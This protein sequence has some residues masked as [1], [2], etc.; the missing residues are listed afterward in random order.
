RRVLR[1]LDLRDARD[2]YRAIRLAQ[3][4]GLGR[5]G[6][7]DVAS[8]PSVS[9]LW[10]M[11]L[12]AA[13]DAVAWEYA[14]DFEAAFGTGLPTLLALRRRRVSVA[15]GI[16][17]T[18][19]TL[20]AERNDT[21]ILRKQGPIAARE[22]SREARRVLAAG[23]VLTSRGRRALRAFDARLRRSR[24]PLNPGA[25]ADLTVASL[26]LWLLCSR[27]RLGRLGTRAGQ[28]PSRQVVRP[29]RSLPRSIRGSGGL[30]RA[31]R[32]RARW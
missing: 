1:D 32:R 8:P 16:A 18:Y 27:P 29:P 2:A 20:L 21:L 25:T 13:R 6:A 14:N 5:V 31:G 3:P 11:R 4:G 22:V 30:R 10:A 9:L 23:G 24:P 19:L 17:Q 28:A 7:Q 12:A 15:A 26:F